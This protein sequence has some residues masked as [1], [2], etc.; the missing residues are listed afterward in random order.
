MK[1]LRKK[2]GSQIRFFMC[3]E[4][5]EQK[6]RPHYHILLF[7]HSFKDMVLHKTT[8]KNF[9]L[10]RSADLEKL[11][12]YGF[13]DIGEVNFESAAYVARYCTKKITGEMADEHY[14][15]VDVTTGL[16]T[17]QLPEY[18]NMSRRPG[19]GSDWYDKFKS[20]VYPNDQIVIRKGLICRPPRY[21]DNKFDK[22]NPNQFKKIQGKR[23][24]Q[25]KLHSEDSTDYRLRVREAIKNKQFNLL[26]R[27]VERSNPK[28]DYKYIPLKTI[29][30]EP[31][32][33]H[34]TQLTT[35]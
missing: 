13:S 10:Y 7:N 23:Q 9:K 24:K 11:W 4:Y 22:T 18:T 16:I 1:R 30:S 5:G 32:Q 3:G 2:F 14:K 27:P 17:N 33:N 28:C 12:T 21:Y 25:A 6:Q 31:S 15:N 29:K 35:R 26:V 20:D 8:K 19:V 34:S